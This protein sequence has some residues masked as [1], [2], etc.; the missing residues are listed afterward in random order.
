MR[1]DRAA[2]GVAAE[3]ILLLAVA[4]LFHALTAKRPCEHWKNELSGCIARCP[5]HPGYA[6]HSGGDANGFYG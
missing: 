5:Q 2:K 6:D 4:L 3:Y 1:A